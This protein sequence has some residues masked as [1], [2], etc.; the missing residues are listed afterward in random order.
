MQWDGAFLSKNMY[1]FTKAAHMILRNPISE[2]SDYF[3]YLFRIQ[4]YNQPI[5]YLFFT[6]IKPHDV[7]HDYGKSDKQY[8]A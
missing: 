2:M 8:L 6:H 5:S 3:V 7:V 1:L 4:H